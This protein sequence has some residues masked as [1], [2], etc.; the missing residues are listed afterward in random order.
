PADEI[1][2]KTSKM[3]ESFA[4]NTTATESPAQKVAAPA[5][6]SGVNGA[7]EQETKFLDVD[8]FE[9]EGGKCR[10]DETFTAPLQP[11]DRIRSLHAKRPGFVVRTYGDGSAAIHW[12][13]REPQP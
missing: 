13:D 3:L 4:T 11:G 12:D 9:K 7:F 1:P 6:K 10:V 8:E 2:P 5:V